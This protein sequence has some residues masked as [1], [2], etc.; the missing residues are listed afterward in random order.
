MVQ[1]IFNAQV[2]AIEE[3]QVEVTQSEEHEHYGHRKQVDFDFILHVQ[4]VISLL[5]RSVHI[6]LKFFP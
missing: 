3:N 6:F 1:E 2:I 4:E 5:S